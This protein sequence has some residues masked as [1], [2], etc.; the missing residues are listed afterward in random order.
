MSD[1]GKITINTPRNM[2]DDTVMSLALAC[3][4]ISDKIYS[5]D[6]ESDEWLLKQQQASNTTTDAE[7]LYGGI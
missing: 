7:D 3:H 1:K 4:G 2:H 6:G 5:D